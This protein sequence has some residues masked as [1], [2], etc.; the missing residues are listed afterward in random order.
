MGSAS[1]LAD[2]LVILHALYV[3][4]VVG[5]FGAIW[6]GYGLGWQWIRNFW[7]RLV[8][9][10]AISQVAVEAALGWPCPL[11]LWENSLRQQAGQATYPG[12]FLAYWAHR[13][14]YW[15]VPQ[16]LLWTLHILFF[17]LVLGTFY[18]IPPQWPVRKKPLAPSGSK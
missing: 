8:H 9:L 13:L 14:L 4:F 15:D 10:A 17:F 7:F 11:T 2:G 16:Q 12:D 1:L 3:G 18:W 5:A 6:L